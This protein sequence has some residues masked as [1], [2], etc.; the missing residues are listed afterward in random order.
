MENNISRGYENIKREAYDKISNSTD[1]ET[2]K[3]I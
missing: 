1:K 3:N 2:K